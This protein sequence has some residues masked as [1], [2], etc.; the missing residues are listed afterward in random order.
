MN[1][2][3]AKEQDTLPMITWE[4]VATSIEELEALGLDDDPLVVEEP[5]LL[6]DE[7]PDFISY[8]FGIC[9]VRVQDNEL[10]ATLSG[11]IDD[12]ETAYIAGF[13]ANKAKKTLDDMDA[14]TFT[15]D[16]KTFPMNAGAVRGYQSIF[17]APPANRDVISL[18]GV[19]ALASGNIGAFKT[20][21]LNKV[22]SIYGDNTIP[23]LSSS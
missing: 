18:E 13:N 20:A 16:S 15:Y 1:Y 17:D 9:H 8:E 3:K 5:R 12:A 11:D 19:Y 4:L 6:D 7:D 22:L 21:Y 14:E 10:V 23:T 2:Y